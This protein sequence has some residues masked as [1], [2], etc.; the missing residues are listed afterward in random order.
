M[1]EQLPR[2]ITRDLMHF[3]AGVAS[4]VSGDPQWTRSL[5]HSI[6]IG[7]EKTC[8]GKSGEYLQG[9]GADEFTDA[10]CLVRT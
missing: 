2:D 1:L 3:P 5:P 10:G 9:L 6:I 7:F 8:N 4:I